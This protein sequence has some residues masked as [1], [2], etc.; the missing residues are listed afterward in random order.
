MNSLDYMNS[1]QPSDFDEKLLERRESS[2]HTLRKTS[3]QESHELVR[4]LFSDG[5][6]PWAAEFS[7]FIEKH[8]AE[9]GSEVKGLTGLCSLTIRNPIAESGISISVSHWL[10]DCLGHPTFA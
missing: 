3:S 5:T 9:S 6:H 2:R 4:T 1:L 8:R 10:W 7:K